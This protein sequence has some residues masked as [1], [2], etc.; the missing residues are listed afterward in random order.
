MYVAVFATAVLA[1][2]R[3]REKYRGRRTLRGMGSGLAT[4][5]ITHKE[6]A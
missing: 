6:K 3:G 1:V 4:F 5:I 2:L